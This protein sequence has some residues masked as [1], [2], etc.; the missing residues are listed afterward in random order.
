MFFFLRLALPLQKGFQIGYRSPHLLETDVL[1]RDI[2]DLGSSQMGRMSRMSRLVLGSLVLGLSN[3]S[4]S[5]GGRNGKLVG[6]FPGGLDPVQ[7]LG[8]LPPS[9]PR[10]PS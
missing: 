3:F 7:N 2:L 9:G 10:W 8:G 6:S 1:V 4:F 5:S